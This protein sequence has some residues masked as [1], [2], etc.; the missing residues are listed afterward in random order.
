MFF[1]KQKKVKL[2]KPEDFTSYKDYV[3]ALDRT[4]YG[5]TIGEYN[6]VIADLEKEEEFLQMYVMKKSRNERTTND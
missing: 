6:K 1:D 3:D 2:P 4:I 5:M